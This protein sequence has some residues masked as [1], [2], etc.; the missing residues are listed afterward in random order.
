MHT[1]E[2]II[3]NLLNTCFEN[4]VSLAELAEYLKDESG[5]DLENASHEQIMAAIQ[6]TDLPQ[7]DWNNHAEINWREITFGCGEYLSRCLGEEK[8]RLRSVLDREFDQ[9]LEMC[10]LFLAAGLLADSF[11]MQGQT[12]CNGFFISIMS[13]FN[14]YLG[15]HGPPYIDNEAEHLIRYIFRPQP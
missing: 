15:W 13:P 11:R 9:L 14:A 2:S 5:R 4:S 3:T 8:K 1:L 6:R 12:D 7:T 10:A